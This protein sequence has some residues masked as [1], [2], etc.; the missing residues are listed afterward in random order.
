M[1]VCR[2]R[3]LQGNHTALATGLSLD[4]GRPTPAE[5]VNI[6]ELRQQV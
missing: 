2:E 5:T 4:L 3:V 6:L 1:M